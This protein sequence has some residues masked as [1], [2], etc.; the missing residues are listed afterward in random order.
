M[1]KP[2]YKN[3]IAFSMMLSDIE[4]KDSIILKNAKKDNS[5]I[6][7]DAIKRQIGENTE[8]EFKRIPVTKSSGII[9]RYIWLSKEIVNEQLKDKQKIQKCVPNS[10]IILTKKSNLLLVK[11]KYFDTYCVT[12]TVPVTELTD[13]YVNGIRFSFKMN[14]LIVPA[15][16]SIRICQGYFM[17][18]KDKAISVNLLSIYRKD[19]PVI[20]HL[21]KTIY[22]IYKN[23]VKKIKEETVYKILRESYDVNF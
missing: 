9:R 2:L 14:R 5:F 1:D 18:S 16:K 13:S 15:D 7:L 21:G 8:K 12:C 22:I 23:H 4:N 11:S 10:K 6:L 20:L 19:V 17:L 3:P